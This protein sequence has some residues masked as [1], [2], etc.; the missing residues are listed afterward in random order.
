MNSFFV[1]FGTFNW[2]GRVR[3]RLFLQLIRLSSQI[4]CLFS[5]FI[6][7]VV[8]VVVVVMVET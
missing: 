4:G 3:L 6:T 7:V 8:L 5:L 1:S 2:S